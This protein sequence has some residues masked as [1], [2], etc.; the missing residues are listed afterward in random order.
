MVVV[1][2]QGR[3][4]MA[5]PLSQGSSMSTPFRSPL[6]RFTLYFRLTLVIF[7][8]Y[9]AIFVAHIGAERRGDRANVLRQQSFALADEPRHSSNKLTRIEFDAASL[10]EQGCDEA[11]GYFFSKPLGQPVPRLRPAK[12]LNEG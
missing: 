3:N 5:H 1:R 12:E 2:N 7:A 8:A 10:R 4:G 9:V 11:Q 6:S